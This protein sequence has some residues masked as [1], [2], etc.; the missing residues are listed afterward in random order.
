MP[1]PLFDIWVAGSTNVAGHVLRQWRSSMCILIFLLTLL[2]LCMTT[3]PR[4][5]VHQCLRR[6]SIF[7]V[8]RIR[9]NWL[10]SLPDGR[11]PPLVPLSWAKIKSHNFFVPT[12]ERPTPVPRDKRRD[13]VEMYLS[14]IIYL[15]YFRKSFNCIT[16]CDNKAAIII[17]SCG[18]I[19]IYA[20]ATLV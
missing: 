7:N 20:S 9:A 13:F 8:I 12:S 4:L 15:T 1:S 11:T 2:L 18:L 14:N 5:G 19:N 3:V 16:I 10:P 17:G 6:R